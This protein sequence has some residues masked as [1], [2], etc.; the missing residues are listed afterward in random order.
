MQEFVREFEDARCTD[1]TLIRAAGERQ[2]TADFA[3]AVATGLTGE[4]KQIHSRFLYDAEGS[5][6]F[7]EIT[8]QPEY[9]PTRTEAGILER[10]AGDIA[11]EVGSRTLVELGS[12]YSVK[13]RHLLDAFSSLEASVEYVP[14]DVSSDAIE[15][16]GRS[17]QA[18]FPDVKFTGISGTYAAA[19]PLLSRLTPQM[20]V[21]LGSTLG[22]FDE[23]EHEDFWRSLVKHVPKGD[24][25]LLGV[26]LVKDVDVLEAAYNDAAGVTARFTKNL[27]ARMNGEL[28]TGFDLDGIEHIAEWNPEGS[29]IDICAH[30]SKDQRI[31][32]PASDTYITIPAGTRIMTETSRK[33]AIPKVTADLARHGFTL[34]SAFT[35]DHDWF[36]LLLLEHTGSAS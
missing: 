16:A 2:A 18:H 21:F 14:I 29:S 31:K 20:L 35:D 3:E 28:G 11:R 6:L 25:F 4:V 9:Y 32:I 36:A 15:Q 13:T 22:N 23:Q 10:H 24:H 26:D 33:F 17:I 34:R 30:V 5:R 1:R 8:R 12:G 27:F 7:E 19:F